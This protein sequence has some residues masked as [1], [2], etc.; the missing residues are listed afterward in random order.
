MQMKSCANGLLI[1]CMQHHVS[2]IVNMSMFSCRWAFLHTDMSGT[3]ILLKYTSRHYYMT[4]VFV[5]ENWNVQ[6]Q[7]PNSPI[8]STA[9]WAE[10]DGTPQ[11]GWV[12]ETG[13]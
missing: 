11:P 7:H 9:S 10:A 8:M 12:C 1:R 4:H 6:G 13:I 3:N 2:S 5:S